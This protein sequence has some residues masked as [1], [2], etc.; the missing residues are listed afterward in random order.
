MNNIK[1]KRVKIVNSIWI[2]NSGERVSV[3]RIII[4]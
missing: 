4:I 2:V 3:L 1:K